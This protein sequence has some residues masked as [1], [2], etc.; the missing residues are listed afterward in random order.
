MKIENNIGGFNPLNKAYRSGEA[1]GNAA[2]T[3]GKSR[4]NGKDTATLSES[5][6]LLARARQA[7]EEAGDVRPDVV[8]ALRQQVEAG[9]YQ[10]PLEELVNKLLAKANMEPG[11]AP[12]SREAGA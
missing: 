1:T 9:A 12:D 2:E 8:A 5:A 6:R 4:L 10:A 7:L 3:K 11:E